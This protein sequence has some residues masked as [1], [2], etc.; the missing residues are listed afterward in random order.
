MSKSLYEIEINKLLGKYKS[1]NALYSSEEYKREYPRLIKLY[2]ESGLRQRRK[3]ILRNR[4]RLKE[5]G[6]NALFS[7][8]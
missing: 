8:K 1:K 2:N 7:V 5:D 6:M 3:N 4:R